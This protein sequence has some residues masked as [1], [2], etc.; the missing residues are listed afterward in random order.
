[1]W[2]STPTSLAWLQRGRD[3]PGPLCLR[4]AD[5]LGGHQESTEALS[6][7]LIKPE[8]TISWLINQ[9][10]TP[11]FIS[12]HKPQAFF[13]SFFFKACYRARCK[14]CN[15]LASVTSS[16][17]TAPTDVDQFVLKFTERIKIYLEV[18]RLTRTKFHQRHKDT[19]KKKT[20]PR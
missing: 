13:N 7:M 20:Y 5:A 11:P 19:G 1:M 16:V 12:E 9:R 8:N 17:R 3:G 6:A 14:N 18:V 15:D 4:G 2:R 10:K